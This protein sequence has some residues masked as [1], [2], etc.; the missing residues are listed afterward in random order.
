MRFSFDLRKSKRLR[1]NPRR[2][3][4]FEEARELLSRPI[5]SISARRSEQ[6]LAVGWVGNR[7]SPVILKSANEEG[8]VL[9]LSSGRSTEDPTI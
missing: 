4:G 2:G 9:H 5:G 3:I 6:F 7:L 8:E 1:T